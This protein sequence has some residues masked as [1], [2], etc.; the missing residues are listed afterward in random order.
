MLTA[1]DATFKTLPQGRSRPSSF[2]DL[3][4]KDDESKNASNEPKQ[5]GCMAVISQ[6]EEEEEEEESLLH[7]SDHPATAPDSAHNPQPH[8]A[9]AV[10]SHP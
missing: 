3:R 2:L 10:A 4:G 8:D 7:H 6:N 1:E 9:S 5:S